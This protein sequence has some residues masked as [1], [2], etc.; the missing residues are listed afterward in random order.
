MGSQLPEDYVQLLGEMLGEIG[1]LRTEREKIVKDI[2]ESDNEVKNLHD[3]IHRL[4]KAEAYAHFTN[5]NSN[6][7]FY[8]SSHSASQTGSAIVGSFM[9]R[10]SNLFASFGSKEE[11]ISPR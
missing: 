5:T 9:K 11:L 4:N 2:S 1:T 6:A 8:S 7:I 3:R 10:P